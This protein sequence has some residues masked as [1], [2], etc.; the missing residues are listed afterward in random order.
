MKVQ[1]GFITSTIR[2]NSVLLG[3]DYQALNQLIELHSP[4]DNPV[5]MDCCHNQ[6]TIWQLCQYQPDVKMDISS[7]GG[8]DA[9]ADFMT[10]PFRSSTFDVIVFDPPHL[11]IAAASENSSGL[12]ESRYGITSSG[13]G[14]EGDNVS[15]MFAPFL[16]EARRVLR[17]DGVVLAKIADLVHNHA[18]QW[19]QVDFVNACL[20]AGL[21]PCDMLIK[22]D[23]AAG[24]LT[25][26]KWQVQNHL[27]K[28]HCYW[29]VARNGKSEKKG[30]GRDIRRPLAILPQLEMFAGS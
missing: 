10:L 30:Q 13:A 7:I 18:Y 29:I 4:A 3:K 24:N 9:M 16:K 12:W 26:S 6:G 17:P 20:P 22:V 21:T 14:R 5:I 2:Y 28:G 11:P 23:P 25:S 15:G 8:L 27:R 19:Q 1:S